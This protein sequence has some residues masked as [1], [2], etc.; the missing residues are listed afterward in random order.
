MNRILDTPSKKGLWYYLLP[1]IEDEHENI[2]QNFFHQNRIDIYNEF[3][4]RTKNRNYF[5]KHDSKK[6]G[7]TGNIYDEVS[8]DD[9]I[10]LKSTFKRGSSEYLFKEPG[11]FFFI[12]IFQYEAF[13]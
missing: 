13:L 12:S 5:R 7:S 6:S 1:I 3:N 11:Y 9:Y 4:N 8:E 10:D 2:A